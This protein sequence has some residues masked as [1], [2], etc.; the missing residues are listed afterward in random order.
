MTSILFVTIYGYSSFVINLLAQD[1]VRAMSSAQ[2]VG[3]PG[4]RSLKQRW[5][6][7]YT[8]VTSKGKGTDQKFIDAEPKIDK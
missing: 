8:W 4:N 7:S 2:D 3:E 1:T 6:S 5:I